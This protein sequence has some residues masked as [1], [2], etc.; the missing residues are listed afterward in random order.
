VELIN[1]E[2][3]RQGLPRL[4]L[5]ERL[6][7]A[8][9]HHSRDMATH[10]F[11]S[12]IGSDGSTP[13]DRMR[14]AGYPLGRGDEVLAANSG[15]PAAVL[16]A[17]MGSLPHRATLMDSEFV[18]IG[19]GYA[20][21]SDATYGHYW[22]V[23]VAHPST[24]TPTATESPRLPTATPMPT[25]PPT[26]TPSPATPMPTPSDLESRLVGLIN[27]ERARQALS[28]LSLDERL[29]E[30]AR[31]H[32]QDMATSDF[33]SHTGS[34]GSTPADRMRAAGYPLGRGDEVLAANSGDPAVVLT[35]WMGSLPHRATLMDSEFVHIGVGYAFHSDATY[36]HYWT[37][38]VALP[39]ASSP[40]PTPP[41]GSAT[42]ALTPVA[43]AVGWIMSAEETGNHFGDDDMYTGIFGGWI[44]H[45]AV[46]FDLSPIPSGALIHSAIL[47]LTGQT[48]SYLS[49]GGTWSLQFLSPDVDPDWSAHS[50]ADIHDASVLYTIPPILH[51]E[52][53]GVEVVNTFTFEGTHLG[54]LED[55]LASTGNVSL[56]LDGPDSG[57]NN[58]FSWDSGYW[59]G[60]LGI[61]P[62]LQITYTVP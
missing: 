31:C 48:R 21:H 29:R 57:S 54:A 47:E 50:F 35:A 59:S 34:D 51:S 43:D 16:T 42:I 26:A 8:A 19:V 45:G 53:L 23:N 11:F 6:L 14:A 5:D 61:K 1:Q 27:Q 44:Y 56:R 24:A 33:F 20:F 36:G 13:Q 4:S 18:H 12:Q 60:G 2:R 32:S 30:A 9:R 25:L 39:G 52:D 62:I 3:T 38:N 37:V 10:N 22:T 55:R 17:W 28:P 58:V 15:D 49:N 46:Q 41:S 40:T 7:E